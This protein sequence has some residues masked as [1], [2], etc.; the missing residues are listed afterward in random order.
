MA[1]KGQLAV[2]GS[3]EVSHPPRVLKSAPPRSLFLW[4]WFPE[5]LKSPPRFCG[6]VSEPSV[7]KGPQKECEGLRTEPPV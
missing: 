5:V 4:C 3:S 6:R 7:L 2:G 1:L